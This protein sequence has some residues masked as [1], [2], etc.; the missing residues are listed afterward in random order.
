MK[1]IIES[2][3]HKF[4]VVEEIPKNHF[5]WN[6]GKNMPDGYL[7][8]AE[9]GETFYS[10]NTETLK[11]IE[12]KEAQIILAA[13]GAGHSTVKKMESLLRYSEKRKVKPYKYEEVKKAL[14]LLKQVKGYKNLI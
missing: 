13:I 1:K 2:D 5:L 4:E 10:V 3:N 14:P 7:P 12:F 8:I 11:A 6:I 9:Q